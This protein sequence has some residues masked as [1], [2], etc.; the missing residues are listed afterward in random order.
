MFGRAPR[1]G[2]RPLGRSRSSCR[3][4]IARRTRPACSACAPAATP[5]MIGQRVEM[6]ALRA[7]GSEFPVE[8]VLWRT[9]VGGESHFTASLTDLSE[10]RAAAEQ[11]ER[12]REALRQS[13]KLVGDGQPAGRRGA[14]AEQ[15]AGHRDGPRQPARGEVRRRARPAG[16][17]AAHPRGRRA[18]R[19]HRAHLPEHGA[20]QAG[21]ARA[22]CSSTTWR[23][24]RST[25]WPT[26]S[27]ATASSCS[28]SSR[29]SCPRCSADADQIGQVVLNLLVNAQQALARCRRQPAPRAR[30]HRHRGAARAT[31][32]RASGCAWPTTGRASPPALREKHLRAL[33]HHQAGGH[34]HRPR[35]GGV[36]LAGARPWR[37]AAAWRQRQR[38]RVLPP[39]PAGQRR[40][41][42]GG[43]RAGAAVG[44]PTAARRRAC[45]WS[46]TSP[47]SPS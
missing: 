9:A 7:D 32:S 27:A 42:A 44:A 30:V 13:E 38:R 14:R 24:P 36:A 16:R 43:H 6:T 2:A 26:P 47:R 11:I 4:A 35:P 39:E 8:M 21:A 46:T 23:A 18:L 29:P 19:P 28:S 41:A 45:W 15:P 34:R 3:R 33:L 37:R 40:S 5:H 10:R 17:R 12:Q 20:Q 31:A 22:T 25:C 1:R